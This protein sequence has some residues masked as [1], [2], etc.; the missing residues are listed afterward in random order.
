MKSVLVRSSSGVSARNCSLVRSTISWGVIPCASAAR[1]ILVPCSSVP[2][3]NTT[4]SPHSRRQRASVSAAT[5]RVRVP[6]VGHVV[7][8]VDG[9]GDVE[10]RRSAWRPTL[11]LGLHGL[12]QTGCGVVDAAPR[13][14]EVARDARRGVTR[15][16]GLRR[17]R[18]A[19]ARRPR[20]RS[21]PAVGGA[22]RARS[23]TR[24]AAPWRRRARPRRTARPA[25]PPRTS[26]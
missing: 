3:R 14:A 8:V 22:G 9:R 17:A 16:T 19:R 20:R 2:V 12:A 1:S 23:R 15:S 10:R 11:F 4:S 24:R 7:R 26:S 21:P 5:E 6:D 18:P 13:H 25:T